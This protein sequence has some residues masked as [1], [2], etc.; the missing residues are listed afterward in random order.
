MER[1]GHECRGAEGVGCGRGCPLPTPYPIEGRSG[2]G[3]TRKFLQEM[4]RFDGIL[5]VN[6]KFYFMN[7]TV[8][9]L[10]NPDSNCYTVH[11]V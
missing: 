4:A 1:R 10:Q 9:I 6:F 3:S 7:K 2:R 5:A 11:F 8:K